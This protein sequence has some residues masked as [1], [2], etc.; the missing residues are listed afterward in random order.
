[1][2]GAEDVYTTDYSIKTET[3]T[4]EYGLKWITQP[5]A[6]TKGLAYTTAPLTSDLELTGH[7]VVHLWISSTATD[8]DFIVDLEDID[9]QDKPRVH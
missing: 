1:M 5:E 7:P 9:P 4:D 8:G 2:A 6:S 3:R